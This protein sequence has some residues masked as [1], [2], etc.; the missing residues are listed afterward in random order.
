MNS[1]RCHNIFVLLAALLMPAL[2]LAG[3]AQFI[4]ITN[5]GAIT[6]IQF[7]GLNNDV[8]IIPSTTN[9][10]PVTQIG[11]NAFANQI[12]IT[13]V[14]IPSSITNIGDYAFASCVS[15]NSALIMD[16]T[17]ALM[18]N[19]QAEVASSAR[20]G[21]YAFE[22]CSSLQSVT[23][24]KNVTSIGNGV[25]S[26][27]TNLHQAF[28]QGNAPSVNGGLI[29]GKV[30]A[31]QG[32]TG[33]VYYVPGTTG[34]GGIFS[35]WLTAGWYQPQPQILG[36]DYGLGVN[37]NGFQFTISWATNA[38]VVVEAAADLQHWTPVTTNTLV[39]GTNAFGDSAI[40]NY[41]QRFYRVRSP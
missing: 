33:T 7:T 31:F 6:I 21:D 38:S 17:Y 16:Q 12:N 28:F 37:S 15:L 36:S 30:T 14:I 26:G 35:G 10:Y 34:W 4:Y 25:F 11:A 2:P 29:D 39:N 32:E 5:N 40:T 13:N 8:I 23:I 9:G 22:G 27:C 18:Q 1:Q 24:P 3:R 41:S 19:L 20:I